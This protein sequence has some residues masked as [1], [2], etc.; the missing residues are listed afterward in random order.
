M[1]P[2]RK[3]L[4]RH[5]GQEILLDPERKASIG[6]DMRCDLVLGGSDGGFLWA[7][8]RMVGGWCI[9]PLNG[10]EVALGNGPW[11]GRP[12]WIEDDGPMPVRL[13]RNGIEARLEIRQMPAEGKAHPRQAAPDPESAAISPPPHHPPAPSPPPGP[14]SSLPAVLSAGDWITIGRDGGP[15]DWQFAGLD[16]A[17]RHARVRRQPDGSLD[18]RD[19]SHGLGV[20]ADGRPVLAARIPPGKSFII[21]HHRWQVDR[22]GV[23]VETIRRSPVLDCHDLTVLYRD[24]DVPSLADIDFVLNT[25]EFMTVIGPSSAGKSTLFRALLGE[26]GNVSGSVGFAGEALPASGLPGSL[27]SF[28]PQDDHLPTDLTVRQTI[29]LAARLRLAADL[30]S[31]ELTQRIDDVMT[32]LDLSEHAGTDI[33]ALSGGTRKRV[34]LALELLSDPILLILD[35]PTS[36]LD[37]GLDRRLMRLLASLARGNTAILLVTHS[38]VNLDESDQVLAI[39]GRGAKGYLGSPKQMLAAFSARTYADV[40]DGLRDGNSVPE[41]RPVAMTA[42]ASGGGRPSRAPVRRNQILVLATR[43]LRRYIPSMHASRA[44]RRRMVAKPMQHLLMAPLLVA[45]LSCF[46]GSSGLATT[47]RSPNAQL[48][49]VLSVLSITAA[50]FAAAVTS[51]SIVSDYAMI[52][53]ETRWGIRAHSVIISRFLVF[54][55]IALL[56]GFLASLIFLAFKPGPGHDGP[57]PGPLLMIVSLCLLCLASAGAGLFVSAIA[58]TVQQGVFALMMLSVTQVVL[59]G[60]ITPLGDPKNAGVW[61]LAGLSWA[62]PIRW[63]VAALGSGINLDSVPGITPDR[64]WSHD[65]IHLVG[66]WAALIVLTAV[67]LGIALAVLSARLRRRL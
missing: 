13:R 45:L 22:W 2:G 59:S 58:H 25:D 54:G 11:R 20:F 41:V 34:S 47:G 19:L 40:M 29:R 64:L 51:G 26:V 27:V 14:P 28:L 39:N 5:D 63:A 1:M 65:L 53:R 48:T 7:T 17:L 37:E 21:G 35:E 49:V 30:S 38:M 9:Q 23:T 43:E 4:C 44:G 3:L 42:V 18:I 8:T 61:T 36:G 55:S 31:A 24:K 50:F 67:F 33:A 57:V 16:V 62:T 32:R 15:A 6:T 46:V 52:K 60:L 66:A 56:Q 12:T 10:T